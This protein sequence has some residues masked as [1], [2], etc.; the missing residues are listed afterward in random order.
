MGAPAP[1]GSGPPLVGVKWGGE[2]KLVGPRAQV[3]SRLYFGGH[4][5]PFF[6]PFLALFGWGAMALSGS[7]TP[8]VGV[9]WG[10][11]SKLVGPEGPSGV[12]TLFWGHF[13]PF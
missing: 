10:G 4:F 3:A 6:G 9:K 12:C 5:W 8:I 1:S 2:S 11:E 13:W 7:G